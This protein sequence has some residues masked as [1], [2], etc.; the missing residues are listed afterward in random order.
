LQIEEGK[1]R[2]EREERDR[3][4]NQLPGCDHETWGENALMNRIL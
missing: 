1:N 3:S 4:E 2:G